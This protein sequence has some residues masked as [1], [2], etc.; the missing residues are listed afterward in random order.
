M[1]GFFW[2]VKTYYPKIIL[3][4]SNMYHLYYLDD[5]PTITV[6]GVARAARIIQSIV[7]MFMYAVSPLCT[8]YVGIHAYGNGAWPTTWHTCPY[9]DQTGTDTTTLMPLNSHQTSGGARLI[10][11]ICGFTVRGEEQPDEVRK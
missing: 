3:W 7:N 10:P 8:Y 6:T 2:G 5:S 11:D 4:K 9:G 1:V